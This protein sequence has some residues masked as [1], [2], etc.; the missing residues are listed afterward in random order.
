MLWRLW[1]GDRPAVRR[2]V[3]LAT[4]AVLLGA[5]ALSSAW[6]L[7]GTEVLSLRGLYRPIDVLV[8]PFRSS[9]RFIWSL[10][11]FVLLCA[12]GFVLRQARRRPWLGSATL[13]AILA[14][15][16]I[17]AKA[18]WNPGH[19]VEAS[20]AFLPSP[21]WRLARGHYR[22][23]VLYP[24]IIQSGGGAGCPGAFPG[25]IFVP[26]GLLAYQLGMSTNSA[27]VARIDGAPAQA[28]CRELDAKMQLG[29]FDSDSIYLVHPSKLPV[30]ER[31]VD[32]L[33]CGV[34]D[35]LIACVRRE[36]PDPFRTALLRSA[37]R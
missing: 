35:H 7:A 13:A 33:A 6:K 22:H 5:F 31:Y 9:G 14:V 26:V 15:Q 19:P 29:V 32:R 10:H 27:Y 34:V 28:Y 36:N 25:A 37:R 30:I 21:A 4:C 24:P 8:A 18:G 23:L 3:P 16:V 1:R 20:W 11:Y 17:D 12:I 2:L